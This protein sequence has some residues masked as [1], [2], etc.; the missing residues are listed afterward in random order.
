M[1]PKESAQDYYFTF[2]MSHEHGNRYVKIHGTFNEARE[3]MFAR[4]GD[5]WAFQ[6]N[7]AQWV[8]HGVSQA[9]LFGL[10]ELKLEDEK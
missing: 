8:T 7:I 4:F 10:T 9:E 5:K 3:K 2:E 6:Y 1:M